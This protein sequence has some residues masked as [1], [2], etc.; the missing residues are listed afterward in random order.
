MRQSR[1][2]ERGVG[3]GEA[4]LDQ[5]TLDNSKCDGGIIPWELF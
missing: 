1:G 3:G 4:G 5:V 2:K